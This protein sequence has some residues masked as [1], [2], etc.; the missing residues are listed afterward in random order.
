M[1][2]LISIFGGIFAWFGAN[3][4]AKWGF[5]VALIAAFLAAAAAMWLVMLT[6]LGAVIGLM[7]S[8]GFV[9]FTL[10]F[11]PSASAVSAATT[12][13]YG[14]MLARKAW[15]FWVHTYGIASRMGAS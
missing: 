2:A 10:Q 4:A 15:E 7:P 13:Y 11:F 9:P 14:S 3:L 5:K 12:A 6:A 8:H 1:S